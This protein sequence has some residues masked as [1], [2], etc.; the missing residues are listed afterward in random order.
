LWFF[1]GGIGD[2]DPAFFHFLLFNRLH[3]HPISERSYVN[4][5]HKLLLSLLWF[6]VVPAAVDPPAALGKL[7]PLFLLVVVDDFELRIDHIAFAFT[8]AFFSA[9]ARL[10][11]GA[12]ACFWM[13]TGLR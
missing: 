6:V 11:L 7:F 5:C 1:L 9:S 10:R 3:Q 8:R 13:R 2:D 4:C 12:R